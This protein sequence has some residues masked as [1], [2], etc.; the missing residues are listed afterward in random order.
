VR[1]ERALPPALDAF[2]RIVTDEIALRES[3]EIRV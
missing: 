2:V 3:R 1:A